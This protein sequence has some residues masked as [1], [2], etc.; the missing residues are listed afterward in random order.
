MLDFSIADS[1]AMNADEQSVEADHSWNKW[2][3]KGRPGL[4]LFMP[5]GCC[6]LLFP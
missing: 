1:Y 3:G 4:S 6:L 2:R 5:S